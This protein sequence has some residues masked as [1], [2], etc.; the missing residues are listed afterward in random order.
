MNQRIP[1]VLLILCA[2][3]LAGAGQDL[4]TKIE[5]L[6]IKK[7][8]FE[9]PQSVS[10]AGVYVHSYQSGADGQLYNVYSQNKGLN[11]IAGSDIFIIDGQDAKPRKLVSGGSHP[12][13][14]PDG[15][16]LAYCTWKGLL[17]G[18]IEVV[19]V[20]GTG[21][22]QITN[23]KGGACFP[24]WSPDGTKIA[25]TALISG[26]SE[27]NL[28]TGD[29]MVAKNSEIFVVDKNGG[30]P[31]AIIPGYAA[32]WSPGGTMLVLLRG[33]EK[34]DPSGSVWLA[35]ADGKKSKILVES[36]RRIKGAAWLP[37][38]K[39]IAVS[40]MFSGKYS[41][42][43]IYI[44]GSQSQG[45]QPQRIGGDARADWSEPGITPDGKHAI[46]IKDCASGIGDSATYCRGDSI[47]LLDLDT[48]KD[49]TLA[50][51]VNYSVVWER[52]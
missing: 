16:E 26:D 2:G 50:G 28:L 33:P 35:T 20:D 46:A 40:S 42:F 39:G 27:K 17:F 10:F 18:Q 44:D 43:R 36:N 5:T 1:A 31:V 13:L 37:D 15:S 21:R 41:I 38:G 14:S 32:R 9:V 45:N 47:A 11:Q 34:G 29:G 25:F 19:N 3:A 30:D 52:R 49:V 12:A 7:L 51:G 6:G 24:D 22:R 48:N 8:A 4:P 23:M